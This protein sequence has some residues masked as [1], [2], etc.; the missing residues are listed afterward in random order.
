VL[1]R[2]SNALIMQQKKWA[3]PMPEENIQQALSTQH[4]QSTKSLCTDDD[5]W[6]DKSQP[7]KQGEG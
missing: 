1:E 3:F 5:T 4:T 6:K 7:Y 2:F